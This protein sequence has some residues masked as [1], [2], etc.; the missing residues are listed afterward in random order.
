VARR[1][2]QRSKVVVISIAVHVIVGAILALVPQQKLREV[3]AIAMSEVDKKEEKKP[4][5]PKPPERATDRPQRSGARNARPT[6]AAAEASPQNDPNAFQDIGLALDSSA[7]GGI[8]VAIAKPEPIRPPPAPV[9]PPR[10]KVLMAKPT[11]ENICMEEIV[12]PRVMKQSRPAYT[13]E[14][15]KNHVAGKIRLVLDVDANG[16]VVAVRVLSGLGHGLDEAAIAAARQFHFAPATHC[17][18]PT[19]ASFT[20]AMRFA[21]AS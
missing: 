12:K 17:N 1:Q 3:V 20:I 11:T 21:P 9:A 14:A 5:P 18:R 15:R 6:A 8:A 19:P 10:P 16:E 2:K 7:E 13:D 4:E